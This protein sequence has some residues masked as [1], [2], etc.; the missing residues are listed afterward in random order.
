MNAPHMTFQVFSA[1]EHLTTAVDLASVLPHIFCN[2]ILQ[3][4]GEYYESLLNVIHTSVTSTGAVGTRRPRLFL[5]RFGT[6]T[7]MVV[8]D[9]RK[10]LELIV[11]MMS[12]STSSHL[13]CAGPVA[14]RVLLS[15]RLLVPVH[16]LP[17]L[18]PLAQSVA[19]RG[20]LRAPGACE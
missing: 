12:W 1:G 7:G 5:V 10:R 8:L 15:R 16:A 11:E 14:F 3:M 9:E 6:G 18:I 17:R 4:N 13:I 19:L 20:V 2:A